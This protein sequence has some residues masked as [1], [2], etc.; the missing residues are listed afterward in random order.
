MAYF[1]HGYPVGLDHLPVQIELGIGSGERRKSSLKWNVAYLKGEFSDKLKEKWDSLPIEAS[2]LHKLKHITKLYRQ[3]SKQQAKE[4]K[5]E[6]LNARAKFE[7]AMARLHND[8]YNVELQGKVNQYK[9][10]IEEIATR[11][12]RGTSIRSKVKWQKLGD[13]CSAKFF[14]LVKQKNSQAVI[15]E[16]RDNQGRSFTRKEDL[17]KICLDFYQNL[18][19]HQDISGEAIREVLEGLPTTFTCD[20]NATLSRAITKNELSTAILLMAKGKAPGHN[21]IPIEFFQHHWPSIGK[22]CLRMVLKGIEEGA[23][24]EGVTK[25]LIV[26]FQKRVILKTSIIGGPLR[27]LPLTIKYSLTLYNLGYSRCLGM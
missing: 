22:D 5:R 9:R 7:V 26:L 23:F 1:I 12:A 16:L 10:M 25:G 17:G 13:K 24:H 18:Y 4:H 11:K 19:M 27:S 6:E 8:I 15:L 21:G 2:F 20:M 14:R 3:F